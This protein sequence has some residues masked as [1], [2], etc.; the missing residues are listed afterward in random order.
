MAD[1]M[2]VREAAASDSENIAHLHSETFSDAP[3]TA[4]FF[5]NLCVSNNHLMMVVDAEAQICGFALAVLAAD[6]MEILTLAISSPVRRR[7]LGATLLGAIEQRGA[8]LG[9]KTALLDVA[10]LNAAA[11]ALYHRAGYTPDGV[12]KKYYGP[13]KDAVLMSK[14]LTSTPPA[15]D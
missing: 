11:L 4:D 3:W 12:R 1:F 14:P 10:A 7:G 8:A 15:S 5:A 6:Q 9:V 2:L 13:G